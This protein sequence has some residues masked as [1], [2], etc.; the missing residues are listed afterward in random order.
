MKNSDWHVE[1][2]KCA[3]R[4]RRI[5]IRSLSIAAGLSPSTFNNA[6]RV[7][8]PKA[9]RAIAKALGVE[10]ETIWPSRYEY[11][12]NKFQHEISQN[13]FCQRNQY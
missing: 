4:K 13:S 6:L 9:E 12:S 5:S 2:I 8:Y 3:L 1:D 7:S 10:P 11:K